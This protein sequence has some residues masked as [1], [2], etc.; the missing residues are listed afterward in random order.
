LALTSRATNE[1]EA[2]HVAVEITD[3]E[4]AGTRD[5]DRFDLVW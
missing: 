4:D 1:R 3:A 2:G 5:E